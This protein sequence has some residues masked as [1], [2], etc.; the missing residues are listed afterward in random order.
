MSYEIAQQHI[1]E[2]RRTNSPRL[3][4]PLP[5]MQWLAQIL[6]WG[7]VLALAHSYVFFPLLMKWLAKGKKPNSRVFA[8]DD[9]GSEARSATCRADRPH[10][11]PAAD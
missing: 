9:P 4:L 2:A 7:S 11:W 1:A 8:A 10:P 6:L 3:N 5:P